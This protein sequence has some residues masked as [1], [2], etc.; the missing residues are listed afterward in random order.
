MKNTNAANLTADEKAAI[1]RAVRNANKRAAYQKIRNAK[2][3]V[4]AKRLE[5]NR[6]RYTRNKALLK[7]AEALG[8]YKPAASAKRSA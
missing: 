8:M 5:Y 3:E 6:K 7:Q 4:K 2:P 1:E